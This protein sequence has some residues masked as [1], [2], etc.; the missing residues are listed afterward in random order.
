MEKWNLKI[1]SDLLQTTNYV[2]FLACYL[3]HH[4]FNENRRKISYSTFS[5]RAGYHSKSFLSEILSGKKLLTLQSAEKFSKG[6]SLNHSLAQYF[7]NL[8]IIG[9]ILNNKLKDYD[10]EKIKLENEKIKQKCLSRLKIVVEKNDDNISLKKIMLQENFPTVYAALGSPQLGSSFDEIRDRTRMPEI[11]LK[12]ILYQMSMAGLV[13][14][15]N[16]R[17]FAEANIV[18]FDFMNTDEFFKSNYKRSS[19]QSIKRLDFGFA[20]T[21]SL[22]MTQTFSVNT[23]DLPGLKERLK[24]IVLEFSDDAE[25]VEGDNIAEI[26]ISFTCVK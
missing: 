3:G 8:V 4:D 2:D 19:A 25:D 12:N 11:A 26:C 7:K 23:E 14:L 22:F 9:L 5:K 17:Y 20:N 6:M 16:E 1:K 10:L 18:D 21:R 13:Y 15:S 24:K